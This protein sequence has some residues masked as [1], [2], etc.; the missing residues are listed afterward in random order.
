MTIADERI[1]EFLREEATRQPKQIAEGLAEQGIDYNDKYIGR[2]CIELA[3]FG[4]LRNLG[5]GIYA[6]TDTGE[7]YLEGEINAGELDADSA[8]H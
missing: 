1:L 5:N 6:L 7:A 3:N 8:S 4:L 2:R